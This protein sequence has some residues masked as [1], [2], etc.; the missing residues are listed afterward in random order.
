MVQT[1]LLRSVF[2]NGVLHIKS[3]H[4]GSYM[5]ADAKD[6]IDMFNPQVGEKM[7]R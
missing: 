3:L 6:F 1:L 5:V 2:F 7:G 4:F